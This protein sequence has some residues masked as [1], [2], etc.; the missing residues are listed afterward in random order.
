MKHNSL[1]ALFASVN[2][3]LIASLKCV[4]RNAG[5][6]GRNPNVNQVRAVG[7]GLGTDRLA[8]IR[9]DDAFDSQSHESLVLDLLQHRGKP[10]Q[11]RKRFSVLPMIYKRAIL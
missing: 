1:F 8:A 2:P 10:Q 3:D 5:N 4:V 9:D 7:E 6:A 11:G